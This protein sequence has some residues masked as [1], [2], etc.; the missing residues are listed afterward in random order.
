[1]RKNKLVKKT[2]KPE[3]LFLHAG[4][5]GLTEDLKVQLN[6]Y[7]SGNQS[8][9]NLGQSITAGIICGILALILN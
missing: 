7:Q 1:M 5:R 2:K 9:I 3:V 8:K 6:Q 4:L